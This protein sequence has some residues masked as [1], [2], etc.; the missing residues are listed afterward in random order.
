VYLLRRRLYKTLRGQA[1]NESTIELLGADLDTVIS[2]IGEYRAGFH[3]DHICPM[4]QAK[5]KEEVLL[6]QHYTNLQWISATDNL[7][8]GDSRTS[9]GEAL[10]LSLLGRAWEET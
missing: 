6:L 1:K 9:E 5:T 10:C 3:L 2:C 7:Q 8:K 4:S